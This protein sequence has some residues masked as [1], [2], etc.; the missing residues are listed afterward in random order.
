MM[1]ARYPVNMKRTRNTID[2]SGYPF[3]MDHL[4]EEMD[5]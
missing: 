1:I 4:K 5:T 2:C 3:F